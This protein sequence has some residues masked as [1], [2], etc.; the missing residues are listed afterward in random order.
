MI[1]ILI[2]AALALFGLCAAAIVSG[3][4]RRTG[5]GGGGRGVASNGDAA[6]GS[7]S[8]GERGKPPAPQT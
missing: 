8:V 6:G 2:A 3:R 1:G 4:R 7:E 5:R